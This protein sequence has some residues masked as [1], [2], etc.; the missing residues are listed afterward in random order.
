MTWL[1]KHCV[2]EFFLLFLVAVNGVSFV[3]LLLNLREHHAVSLTHETLHVAIFGLDEGQVLLLISRIMVKGCLF[4]STLYSVLVW[5]LTIFYTLERIK[6][7]VDHRW[8]HEGFWETGLVSVHKCLPVGKSG[9]LSKFLR[10]VLGCVLAQHNWGPL[11]IFDKLTH[12]GHHF[13]M[14][15]K[16]FTCWT[17]ALPFFLFLLW[18]NWKRGLWYLHVLVL[19][20]SVHQH[21]LISFINSTET[22]TTLVKAVV[23]VVFLLQKLEHAVNDVEDLLLVWPDLLKYFVLSVFLNRLSIAV[24]DGFR[25]LFLEG[26]KFIVDVHADQVQFLLLEAEF[27][28]VTDILVNKGGHSEPTHFAC[29]I[30]SFFFNKRKLN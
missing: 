27:E 6:D 4:V 25:I 1:A 26:L 28:L 19:G 3:P 30:K 15:N 10:K 13:I 24:L 22:A 14:F 8:L 20:L 18:I 11:T 17:L 2:K 12:Y 21:V 5:T 7:W 9:V 16:I 23:Q 29:F